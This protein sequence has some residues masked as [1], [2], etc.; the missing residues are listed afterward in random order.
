ME[1]PSNGLAMKRI[2]LYL[3][4]AI[5]LTT[6][7]HSAFGQPVTATPETNP[8]QTSSK[9]T[10]ASPAIEGANISFSSSEAVPLPH[11]AQSSSSKPAN[12]E[13]PPSGQ[14]LTSQQSTGV[15]AKSMPIPFPLQPARPVAPNPI[16]ASHQLRLAP[17]VFE[18]NLLEK[19]GTRFV[20]VRNV[21]EAAGISRYRLP[22][23]DGTDIELVINLQHGTVAV[24]G[25][26]PV[27][28]S[29]LQ[30]VRFLDT[31]EVA[32]GQ[33]TRFMPVQQSSIDSARRVAGIVNHES[34]RVAQAVPGQVAPLQ[35]PAADEMAALGGDI[36][37]SV[38][39][40]VN[41]DIID[42]LGTMVIQGSPRDVAA[43]RAMLQQ[44][45]TISLENEPVIEL[46]PMTHA[47]SVRVNQ[48][49]LQ[50][51]QQVYYQRRGIIITVALV[52][53]NT[54]LIIGRTESIAAV[55]ELIAKLD[56][57]V[58][59]NAAFKIYPLKHAP[60]D[61]A[62]ASINNTFAQ[63]PGANT[64]F[65]LAP[66]VVATADART[67]ALIVQANPRDLLEVEEMI[68]QLDIP[69]SEVTTTVKTFS[70]R[71][72]MAT[73]L[74]QVLQ[75]ALMGTYQGVMGQR[76]SQLEI[77]RRDAEGNLMR[78]SL[79]Y[80]VSIVAD[81]R[82]NRIIVTA[83]PET[84]PLI[85]ALIE[86]LDQLPT[87][88]TGIKV[89][90]LTHADAYTLATQTLPNLF[91]AGT[92]NQVTAIRPGLEP[93]DSPLVAI[94]F[95]ADTR[96]NSIIVVGSEGE[97]T[98]V[99]ALLRRLDSEHLNNRQFFTLKLV[100]V[101]AEDMVTM[102]TTFLN[103]E[104]SIDIQNQATFLPKS[105]L[106]QYQKEVNVI[107]EPISNSLIISTTPS[108]Y[109]QI[110]KVILEFDERP[111]VVAIDVLIAEVTL[112]HGKDRGVE[113]GLQ[114]SILFDRATSVNSVFPGL[115]AGNPASAALAGGVGAQGITSLGVGKGNGFSFSASNESVSIF[116]RALETRNKTQV[117]ARPRLVTLH[118]KRAQID[119]GQEVPYVSNFT[120]NNSGNPTVSTDREQVG[121][122]LDIIPRIMPDWM[123][124]MTVFVR[125][126][127]VSRWVDVAQDISLPE[128]NT[129]TTQTTINAMDGETVIF[130]GLITEEKISR[131]TS[132]PV[133]NKI[134]VVKH[135]FENDTK[136]TKRTELLIALTPRII[137]TREDL[138][139]LNQQEQERMQWCISDV[140]R[141]T[142]NPGMRRRSD[143][144]SPSE[145]RYTPGTSIPLNDSQ[146]PAESKIPVPILLAPEVN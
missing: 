39:G 22:A 37:S 35:S 88:K 129:A 87:A 61:M 38:V 26:P 134:P 93:E 63:R 141:M 44:L 65:N 90:T 34:M 41:I 130:S 73:E 23:R 2:G 64:G 98:V 15:P 131:N 8:V 126:S 74:V 57:P 132:V 99:E 136:N 47:D 56:T 124:A 27:V 85:A 110:R 100:N 122:S 105:P 9:I 50:L 116:V 55:K 43:V 19:L 80:N 94:R 81:T 17:H 4:A 42:A 12:S 121:T 72:A 103:M 117:L 11:A 25:S 111:W 14:P 30:I 29:C 83:P 75:T 48:L 92:T 96:S 62:A 128:L 40:P 60:A 108:Y 76:T 91:A 97:L 70:L 68:R 51:Y 13:I 46:I 114:D 54:I 120:Q 82:N 113:F 135:F 67:N 84:M 36:A 138:N 1:S 33:V 86:Q 106:E 49:V 18:K 5:L 52:K 144:W 79:L 77:G 101:P 146:L 71:Y 119:V 104:R 139:L 133:L 16:T 3:F 145:I 125:R 31:Q 143:E 10:F 127:S 7:A 66:Q 21:E 142:G 137:R 58:N 24:T 78:S 95:Q 59:P 140:I 69:G 6:A 45:E 89:F 118:N 20:P 109:K 53:P 123:I 28:D 112:D 115:S 32:G 107:A 102:L